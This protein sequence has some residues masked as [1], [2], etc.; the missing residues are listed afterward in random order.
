MGENQAK[1]TITFR[2]TGV[3]EKIPSMNLKTNANTNNSLLSFILVL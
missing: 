2:V 1:D 3:K